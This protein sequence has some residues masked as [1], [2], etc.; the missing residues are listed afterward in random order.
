ML[1]S[2]DLFTIMHS[3]PLEHK[4]SRTKPYDGDTDMVERQGDVIRIRMFKS[5]MRTE[6]VR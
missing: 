3:P 1:L 6:Q 2:L 5:R 4:Q